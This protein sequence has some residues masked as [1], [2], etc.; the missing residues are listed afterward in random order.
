MAERHVVLGS[1]AS[2]SHGGTGVVLISLNQKP[3]DGLSGRCFNKP[4]LVIARKARQCSN[5]HGVK[6]GV[7]LYIWG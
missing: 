2:G 6:N 7:D 1:T 3:R 5:I 4:S